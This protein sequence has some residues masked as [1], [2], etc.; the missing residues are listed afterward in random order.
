MEITALRRYAYAP[1]LRSLH[2]PAFAAWIGRMAAAAAAILAI[3]WMIEASPP[4]GAERE[5]LTSACRQNALALPSP[6]AAMTEARACETRFT[7]WN[8]ALV[9]R[10]L[11]AGGAAVA[12]LLLAAMVPTRRDPG[13]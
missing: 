7:A 10:G 1:A 5:R 9:T 2:M 12:L 6:L 8:D 13:R 3:V 4:S 11:L